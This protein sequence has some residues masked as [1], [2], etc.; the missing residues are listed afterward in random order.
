MRQ[1]GL[2]DRCPRFS[3]AHSGPDHRAPTEDIVLE[4]LYAPSWATHHPGLLRRL[5][6][7]LSL[8]LGSLE[9]F[10]KGAGSRPVESVQVEMNEGMPMPLEA[11]LE[12]GTVQSD[13]F[14]FG[15]WHTSG[16]PFNR[17]L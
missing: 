7:L 13:Q 16:Q 11:Y 4:T 6:G 14:Y 9:L 17:S 15:D 12:A 3:L 5:S 8:S 10:G 1:T 2:M